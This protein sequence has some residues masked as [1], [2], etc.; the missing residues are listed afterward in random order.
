[1]REDVEI[2]DFVVL[3]AQTGFA[4]GGA[5]GTGIVDQDVEMAEL[6]LHGRDGGFDRGVRCHVELNGL[7]AVCGFSVAGENLRDGVAAFLRVARPK[8]YVMGAGFREL[9]TDVIAEALVG[10]GDEDNVEW[11]HVSTLGLRDGIPQS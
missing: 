3:G 10:A 6:G 1:M 9:L 2:E 4:V 5:G 8:E 11:R 7:K